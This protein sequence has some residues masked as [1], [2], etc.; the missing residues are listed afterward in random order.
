MSGARHQSAACSLV[1]KQ[2]APKKNFTETCKKKKKRKGVKGD[3]RGEHRKEK[4]NS[5]GSL[6]KP[7][8]NAVAPP[9]NPRRGVKKK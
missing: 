9:F 7:R 5:R 2:V 8:Q 4:T 3:N 1:S 6:L